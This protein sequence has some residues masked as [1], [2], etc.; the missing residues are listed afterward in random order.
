[1]A[2]SWLTHKPEKFV[3]EIEKTL[4]NDL[5]ASTL[6]PCQVLS[7]ESMGVPIGSLLPRYQPSNAPLLYIYFNGTS[8]RRFEMQGF[9]RKIKWGAMLQR[10]IYVVPLAKTVRGPVRLG[11]EKLFG[12]SPFEGGPEATRL[13]ENADLLKLA[14]KLACTS[15]TYGNVTLTIARYMLIQPAPSGSLLVLHTLP[16]MRM[17]RRW[18]LLAGEVM[19]IADMIEASL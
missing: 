10:L 11:K 18:T 13:N 6:L 14:N 15:V 9:V 16:R 19:N 5:N 2:I 17:V 7:P 8:P 4:G 3:P 1:M 12:S